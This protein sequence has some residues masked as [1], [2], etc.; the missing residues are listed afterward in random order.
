M[1]VVRHSVLIVAA[2]AT[3]LSLWG[4]QAQEHPSAPFYFTALTDPACPVTG[5]LAPAP[6]TKELRVLYFPMGQGSTIKQPKSLMVHLVFDNGYGP[7]KEKTQ[8]LTKRDDGV[9]VAAIGLKDTTSKYAI[10]WVSDRETALADT[11]HG[12][13]FEI[14][15][16]DAHGQRDELS[17]RYEA[18]SYTGV[19]TPR[20]IERATDYGKAIE[21]LEENIDP[22]SRGTTLISRLWEYKLKLHR[23]TAEARLVLLAEIKKFI[24]DHSVDGFGL[25]DALNFAAYQDW[26]PS[27]TMESLAKALENKYPRNNPYAFILRAKGLR[28]KNKDRRISLMWELVDKYPTTPEAESARQDLQAEITD[29]VQREKLYQQL[30]TRDPDNPVQPFIMASAYVQAN[31]KLPE[32]L[33]LLDEAKRLFEADASENCVT[34]RYNGSTMRE[35]VLRIATM[36]ADILLRLARPNEALAVLRPLKDRLTSGSAYYLL[37]KAL[38][39]TG[40]QYAAIDAYL[41]SVVRPSGDQQRAN[42][43]LESL[44][45]NNKLNDQQSLQQRIQAKLVRNFSSANYVPR[46][47]GH[48]APDFDLTTLRGER[49][50]S[51]RL[52]GKK[53]ILNFWAVWCGPCL[54]EMK[55]LQDFQERHPELV[56]ATVLDVSTDAEQLKNVIREK[57]LTSL[58]IATAPSE[59]IQRFGRGGVPDTFIIDEDGFVRIEHLGA[60]PDLTH[61]LEADLKAIA[62]IG[63]V[64]QDGSTKH[65]EPGDLGQR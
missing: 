42:A 1:C 33:A 43:A 53:I 5:Y 13:Y 19:L 57:K 18:E 36:Q 16:C 41:E 37:G 65:T 44:W 46:V 31:Q 62:D 17:I 61:Y 32:A 9:W 59:V 54:W 56:V 21:V 25:I 7:D 58:R 55:P 63:A 40:D 34:E 39:Q 30:H 22:P 14:P 27:D 8:A 48:P 52:R 24:S 4:E 35:T 23:D 64:N 38:Q 50:S 45:S 29:L 49:L 12:R 6:V 15:F 20:G 2:F 3:T 10:F 26:F 51:S 11:N 47:L 28:E 60:I